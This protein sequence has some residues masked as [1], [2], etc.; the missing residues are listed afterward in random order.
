MTIS[1]LILFA[2]FAISA[3]VSWHKPVSDIWAG[4]KATQPIGYPVFEI[5][6]LQLLGQGCHF[7]DGIKIVG[8]AD[9]VPFPFQKLQVISA[10][11]TIVNPTT[12]KS[13]SLVIPPSVL[14][15]ADEVIE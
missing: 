10:S 7:V 5:D 12:A 4:L 6:G 1:R 9:T 15:G 11:E 13:L 3:N 2:N 14:N 8:D